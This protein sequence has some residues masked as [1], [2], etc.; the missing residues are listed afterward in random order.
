M[1]GHGVLKA[2][3]QGG[4][5]SRLQS[6]QVIRV[7]QKPIFLVGDPLVVYWN[8]RTYDR[9]ATGQ[10]LQHSGAQLIDVGDTYNGTRMAVKG[11]QLSIVYLRKE[12]NPSVAL[13]ALAQGA[14]VDLIRKAS[15]QDRE[16]GLMQSTMKGLQYSM[17]VILWPTHTRAQNDRKVGLQAKVA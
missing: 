5:K 3:A 1:F 4:V 12:N 8:V 9:G 7:N 6:T 14:R 11:R 2:G 15:C 17:Y 10:R 13:I 16:G